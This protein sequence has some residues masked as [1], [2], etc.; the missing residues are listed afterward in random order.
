MCLQ[1]YITA[2]QGSRQREGPGSHLQQQSDE[3]GTAGPA[4]AG[5]LKL[6][7]TDLT[8]LSRLW[9][10]ALQDYALLTLPSQYSSQLPSTGHYSCS[11]SQITYLLYGK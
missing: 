1:V 5:L 11:V 2:V 4:G 3:A 6:V 9:L 7:Q 8:T 10:A